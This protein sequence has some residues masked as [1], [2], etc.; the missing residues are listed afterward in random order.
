MHVI[1]TGFYTGHIPFAPG[2]WGTILIGIPLCLGLRQLGHYIFLLS[3]IGI[4]F[5]SVFCSGAIEKK[6]AEKDPS[7]IVI[8]EICGFSV[9]MIFLP[10][11]IPNLAGAC[12]LFRLFDILKPYPIRL[13][14][15][16]FPAGW[17]IT[18]DDVLAGI[19]ANLS[20]HLIGLFFKYNT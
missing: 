9:A 4:F 10:L 2:T 17:G 18:L 5:L 20:M 15:R 11:T 14:E 7:C 12:A 3:L 6:L 1:A 8:D 13:L 19:Y 16:R